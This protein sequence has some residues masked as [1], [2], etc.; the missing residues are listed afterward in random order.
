MISFYICMEMSNR[1]TRES[2]YR[3]LVYAVFAEEK[4]NSIK[5]VAADNVK[6]LID[7]GGKLFKIENADGVF[8]GIE[9]A[10][11]NNILYSKNRK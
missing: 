10:N 5:Q 7:A 3:A 1:K 4:D 8:T 6:A 9:V 11:G 2:N